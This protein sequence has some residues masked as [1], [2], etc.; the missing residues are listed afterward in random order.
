MLPKPTEPSDAWSHDGALLIVLGGIGVDE[1]GT[2]QWHEDAKDL[3]VRWE[4]RS[5]SRRYLC[6][7]VLRKA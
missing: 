5:N 7:Q 2:D 6:V 3:D 4:V 1:A